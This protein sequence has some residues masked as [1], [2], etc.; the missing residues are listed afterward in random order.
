MKCRELIDAEL[1]RGFGS[2]RDLVNVV[3]EGQ[4]PDDDR[5]GPSDSRLAFT[6]FS[7]RITMSRWPFF[8]NFARQAV[9]PSTETSM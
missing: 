7:M 8:R 2:K 4:A 9:A 5:R 3:L 1:T 6:R